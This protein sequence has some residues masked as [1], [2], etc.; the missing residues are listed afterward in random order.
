M[1][2]QIRPKHLTEDNLFILI[3]GDNNQWHSAFE[4]QKKEFTKLLQYG[5][6]KSMGGLYS[7][8]YETSK[9]IKINGF[10]YIFVI[11]N[12]WNPCFLVNLDTKKIREVK[13]YEISKSEFHVHDCLNSILNMSNDDI[14]KYNEG[15]SN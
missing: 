4:W 14:S 5:T 10:R 6:M 11:F 3:E 8:T 9:V 7:P 15:R 1:A 12:H 2:F 13:Y